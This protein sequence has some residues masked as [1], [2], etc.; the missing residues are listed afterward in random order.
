MK[1]VSI[2]SGWPENLTKPSKKKLASVSLLKGNREPD[3]RA[4][5]VVVTPR[6]G[7]KADK[8]RED[9]ASRKIARK[10][11]RKFLSE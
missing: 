9:I 3:Y 4:P 2:R 5:K 8:I 6:L 1:Y 7:K 11:L 10:Q